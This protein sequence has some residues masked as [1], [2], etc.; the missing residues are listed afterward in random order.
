MAE[1]RQFCWGWT[2][3][4]LRRCT[5]APVVWSGK[6]F[7]LCREHVRLAEGWALVPESVLQEAAVLIGALPDQAMSEEAARFTLPPSL[8]LAQTL[9]LLA[10]LAVV[11][12][13][14]CYCVETWLRYRLAMLEREE[15]V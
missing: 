13:A 2:G 4:A 15:R 1:P 9:T 3:S 8:T 5:T 10:D 11:E 6:G 14:G 12:R 7:A